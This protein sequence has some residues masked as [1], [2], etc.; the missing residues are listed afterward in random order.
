MQGCPNI[1]SISN[2]LKL[3]LKLSNVAESRCGASGWYLTR[4]GGEIIDGAGNSLTL[5]A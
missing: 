1:Y 3:T 4:L 5:D 2:L